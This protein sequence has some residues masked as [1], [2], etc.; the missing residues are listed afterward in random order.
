MS[1]IVGLDGTHSYSIKCQAIYKSNKMRSKQAEEK[2][3]N[4]KMRMT[5]TEIKSVWLISNVSKWI[6]SLKRKK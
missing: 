6:F 3:N 1:Y 4:E 2:K 5:K